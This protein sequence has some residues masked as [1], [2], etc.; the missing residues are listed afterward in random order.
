MVLIIKDVSS[1]CLHE[2][3]PVTRLRDRHH[4]LMSVLFSEKAAERVPCG[5]YKINIENIQNSPMENSEQVP[6]VL[7]GFTSKNELEMG[8]TSRWSAQKLVM[9]IM[10]SFGCV[11]FGPYNSVHNYAA[12]A[13]SKEQG[14]AVIASSQL[15]VSD[16]DNEQLQFRA[17]TER[18][19]QIKL[20]PEM[21]EQLKVSFYTF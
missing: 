20:T 12:Q 1:W 11:F 21:Q 8:T 4:G 9:A 3:F 14:S 6:S 15:L 17:P 10:I 2:S 7:S 5:V 16:S 13:Y 18:Q 19:P